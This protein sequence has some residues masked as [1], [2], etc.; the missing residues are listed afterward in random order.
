[1]S[2]LLGIEEAAAIQFLNLT[3]N[4]GEA[5]AFP[6]IFLGRSWTYGLA[7]LCFGDLRMTMKH[8]EEGLI[9]RSPIT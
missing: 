4:I 1:M 5:L 6:L 3:A 9:C 7:T 8:R 2:I